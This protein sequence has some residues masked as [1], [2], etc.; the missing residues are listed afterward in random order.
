MIRMD[1][2]FFLILENMLL[3]GLLGASLLFPHIPIDQQAMTAS[4]VLIYL[5]VMTASHL[6]S[7]DR[8]PL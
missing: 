7:E 6:D 5:E 8:P 1:I 3:F 2:I 4:H